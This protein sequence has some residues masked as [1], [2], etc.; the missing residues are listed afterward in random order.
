MVFKLG[1]VV[2]FVVVRGIVIVVRIIVVVVRVSESVRVIAVAVRRCWCQWAVA[3]AG[4]GCC[5]SHKSSQ[6][7]VQDSASSES[8]LWS[9]GSSLSSSSFLLWVAL[10]AVVGSR[11]LGRGRIVVGRIGCLQLIGRPGFRV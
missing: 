11:C 10:W 2:A 8:K 3:E 7:S 6:S 1:V 4:G 9:S 5:S